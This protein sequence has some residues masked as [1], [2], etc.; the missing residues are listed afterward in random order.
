MGN[1]KQDMLDK[2]VWAVVGVTDKTDRLDIK[3]GKN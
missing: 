3:Y 2:K 1:I